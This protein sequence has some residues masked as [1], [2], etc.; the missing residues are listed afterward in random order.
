MTIEEFRN[1]AQAFQAI[2]VAIGAIIASCWAVYTFIK[3]QSVQKAKTELDKL[4]YEIE[5][6]KLE[7]KAV[8]ILALKLE[9]EKFGS[10]DNRFIKAR[11]YVEN[12]G[13]I[14]E[15]I[16]WENS[17]IYATKV[18]SFDDGKARGQSNIKG[19]IARLNG[20]I[21]SFTHLSPK[22]TATEEFLFPIND[23]GIYI[24]TATLVVNTENQTKIKAKYELPGDMIS[25]SQTVYLDTESNA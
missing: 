18:D 23:D 16:S 15:I 4:Q 20:L 5:K 14:D 17:K 6:T 22:E 2:F 1:L 25:Y 7:V 12:T 8:P 24:V 9:A 11:L 3:L 10:N 19:A 13:S 21:A